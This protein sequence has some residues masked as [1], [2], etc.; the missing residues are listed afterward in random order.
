MKIV[1]VF[2]RLGRGATGVFHS[3]SPARGTFQQRAAQINVSPR[4]CDVFSLTRSPGRRTGQLGGERG[5][6]TTQQKVLIYSSRACS[7]PLRFAD[8][9]NCGQVSSASAREF[10]PTPTPPRRD[11]VGFGKR[12]PAAAR[13]LAADRPAGLAGG[14]GGST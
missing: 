5:R 2:L 7:F 11:R 3:A 13:P 14:T 8:D 10:S 9:E 6:E 1:C 12:Q 4:L